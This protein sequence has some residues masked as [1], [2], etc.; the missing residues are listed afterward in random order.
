MIDIKEL[1][2]R[3]ALWQRSLAKLSWEEKLRMAE[4]VRHA[5]EAMAQA[6]TRRLE[7]QSR[8]RAEG[9]A[10]KSQEPS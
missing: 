8:R 9:S 5:A 10:K 6:R 7:E 2:Y 4:S 3:Q 1:L